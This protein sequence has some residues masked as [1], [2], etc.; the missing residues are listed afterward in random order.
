MTNQ[1]PLKINN[2][3]YAAGR[4]V[5][6]SYYVQFYNFDP[7]VSNRFIVARMIGMDMVDEFQGMG[8]IIASG[9]SLNMLAYSLIDT[10]VLSFHNDMNIDSLTHRFPYPCNMFATEYV[11]IKTSLGTNTWDGSGKGKS[12][13][14]LEY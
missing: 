5:M 2:E 10:G 14:L 7:L 1:M 12:N 4:L 13:T 6:A 3:I 8:C 11:T 9:L